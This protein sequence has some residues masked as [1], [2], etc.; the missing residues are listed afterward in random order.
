MRPRRVLQNTESSTVLR[1]LFRVSPLL[2]VIAMLWVAFAEKAQALEV[3][4]VT[5][6]PLG[7][8]PASDDRLDAAQL[9]LLV[10]PIALYSDDLLAL[11]LGAAAHPL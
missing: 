4:E 8:E 10:G 1:N 9:Q 5:P 6:A 2:L 3:V 7:T 11:V